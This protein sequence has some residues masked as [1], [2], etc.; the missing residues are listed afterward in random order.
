MHTKQIVKN[1]GRDIIDVTENKLILLDNMFDEAMFYV[2]TDYLFP[3]AEKIFEDVANKAAQLMPDDYN[4]Y[5]KTRP[6]ILLSRLKSLYK[7]A[8]KN[9]F[10]T[11]EFKINDQVER[12]QL[13]YRWLII[14]WSSFRMK[15]QNENQI[16]SFNDIKFTLN[17]SYTDGETISYEDFSSYRGGIQEGNI[18]HYETYLK[19][20]FVYNIQDIHNKFSRNKSLKEIINENLSKFNSSLLED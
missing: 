5:F 19:L 1:N 8:D 3:S 18:E 17:E 10:L 14:V 11:I 12:D 6:P 2:S 20:Q 13:A 7:E 16:R 15:F 4:E 9:L